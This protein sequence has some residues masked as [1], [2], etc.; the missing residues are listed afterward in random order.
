MIK[1]RPLT[2]DDFPNWLPLWDGN[3]QGTR[4]VDVTSETWARLNDKDYPVHGLCAIDGETMKGLVH[5]IVHPTTGSIAHACYM[6]DVY[7]DPEFRGQGIAKKLVKAVA[8][9]GATQKWSRMYWIAEADNEAA[10]ALYNNIGVKLDF[11]LH[12]MAV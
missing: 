11:T 3:N 10:Q 8:K 9:I 7:V 5:Y 4:D 6:Q 12:V 1:I 2:P